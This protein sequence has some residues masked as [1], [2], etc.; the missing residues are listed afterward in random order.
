MG[1]R[2]EVSVQHSNLPVVDLPMF[3]WESWH[4]RAGRK[5]AGGGPLIFTAKQETEAG[6]QSLAQ[7]TRSVAVERGM[8]VC[9]LS[10][11]ALFP[12]TLLGGQ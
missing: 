2:N 10:P 4:A 6:R 3:N 5:Q 8:W 9:E 12:R 1:S 11:E 7:T